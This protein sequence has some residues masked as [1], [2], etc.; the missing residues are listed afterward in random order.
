MSSKIRAITAILFG[1]ASILGTQHA[2]QADSSCT[3]LLAGL[4]GS[5]R[6]YGIELTM[7][8]EDVLFVSYGQG[9]LQATAGGGFSGTATQTFSDRRAGTQRFDINQADQLDLV[10]S[11][12]GLLQIHYTPDKFDTTW[13]LSCKGTLLTTYLPNYGVVTLR[14]DVSNP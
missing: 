11:N 5:Q 6:I 13:D 2:A 3:S 14:L 12:S 7:H 1:A 9:S 8:R 4:W 10:L